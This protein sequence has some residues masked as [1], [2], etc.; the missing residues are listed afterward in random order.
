MNISYTV[1][2]QES[3]QT[4]APECFYRECS[5]EKSIDAELQN[6]ML[7]LSIGKAS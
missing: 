6:L 4:C 5:A 7:R 3:W 2:V 1:A